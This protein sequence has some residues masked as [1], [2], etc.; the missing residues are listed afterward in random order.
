MFV[1]NTVGRAVTLFGLTFVDGQCSFFRQFNVLPRKKELRRL[2][3]EGS[4]VAFKSKS[5]AHRFNVYVTK[6]KNTRGN[7]DLGRAV[8]ALSGLRNFDYSPV[9]EALNNSKVK[10]LKTLYWVAAIILG[11]DLHFV[12]VSRDEYKDAAKLVHAVKELKQIALG[13]IPGGTDGSK[14][15]AVTEVPID[16]GKE[17][18]KSTEDAVQTG[19]ESV[20]DRTGSGM[21]STE[22]AT[23]VD[24]NG[25]AESLAHGVDEPVGGDVEPVEVIDEEPEGLDDE[26]ELKTVNKDKEDEGSPAEDPA[27]LSDEDK[28]IEEETPVED[29]IPTDLVAD[30]EVMPKKDVV[31][32]AKLSHPEFK[33]AKSWN[34]GVLIKKLLAHIK[35]G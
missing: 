22:S 31:G 14:T 24:S 25:E 13:R 10:G 35:E 16:Q 3:E 9:A 6:V 4:L 26:E 1:V 5:D 7:L 18:N 23:D 21:E 15:E 11:C 12:N 30:L 34:K 2:F 17:E 33:I 28:E 27:G 8:K 19:K 29:E 20:S 32:Y